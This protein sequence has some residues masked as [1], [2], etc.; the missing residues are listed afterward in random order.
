MWIRIVSKLHASSSPTC[1]L[2][3]SPDPSIFVEVLVTSLATFLVAF[4]EAVWPSRLVGASSVTESPTI[5]NT[6]LDM[7]EDPSSSKV[8]SGFLNSLNIVGSCSS[9]SRRGCF[10]SLLNIIAELGV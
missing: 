5:L 4:L 9:S 2:P 3:M 10:Q 1:S 8:S 6:S 7:P